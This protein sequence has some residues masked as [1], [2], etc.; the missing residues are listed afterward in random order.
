MMKKLLFSLIFLLSP[1]VMLAQTDSIKVWNKYCSKADTPL[2]FTGSYNVIQIYARDIKPADIMVKCL[3]NTLKT[4]APEIK[5][6]T[7]SMMA[8]PYATGPKKMRLA[9]M[10]KKTKKVLKTVNFY[11]DTVPAP[12]ARIGT[13]TAPDAFRKDLMA[14]TAMRVAFPNSLYCYPYHITQFTIKMKYGKTDI[15]MPVAGYMMPREL[16][17]EIKNAPDGTFMDFTDIKATCPDC[18]VRP[19]PNV[20]VKIR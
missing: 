3:D 20:R 1:L 13:L 12:I 14:Q 6:D 11:G 7:L 8:M 16:L 9:I 17:Q 10:L 18:G 5:G 19:L 15:T 2:L 4:G